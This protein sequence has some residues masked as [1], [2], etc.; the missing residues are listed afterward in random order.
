MPDRM[1]TDSPQGE[2]RQA[3]LDTFKRSVRIALDEP[4]KG[5]WDVAEQALIDWAFR[6]WELTPSE[7][8]GGIIDAVAGKLRPTLPPITVQTAA[9]ENPLGFQQGSGTHLATTSQRPYRKPSQIRQIQEYDGT[10]SGDAADR[11]LREVDQ[12]FWSERNLA[13]TVADEFQMVA[14]CKNRLVKGAADRLL[15]QIERV[16]KGYEAP[17]MTMEQF[18]E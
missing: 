5:P 17:I 6:T 8:H 18:K 9:P 2:H 4:L 16:E 3:Q 13:G 14:L 12:Y 7:L 15:S 1:K 11:W 10:L